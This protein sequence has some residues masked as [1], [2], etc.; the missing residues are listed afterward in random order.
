MEINFFATST[1]SYVV[2]TILGIQYFLFSVHFAF[3]FARRWKIDS[4]H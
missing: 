3:L 4:I 1:G 2:V